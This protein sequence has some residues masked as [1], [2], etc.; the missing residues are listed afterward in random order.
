M[1]RFTTLAGLLSISTVLIAQPVITDVAPRAAAAGEKIVVR[2][3]FPSGVTHIQFTAHVGG[4][5]GVD[6]KNVAV[7]SA[8]PTMVKVTVPTMA[9]FVPPNAVPPGNPVGSVRARDASGTFSAKQ[10]FVFRQCR[11][12][13]FEGFGA[14]RVSGAK[15]VVLLKPDGGKKERQLVLPKGMV[16]PKAG[17]RVWVEGTVRDDA[18]HVARMLVLRHRRA[19]DIGAQARVGT[20]SATLTRVYAWCDHMPGS[21]RENKHL[22]VDVTL[23]NPGSRP[24]QVRFDPVFVSLRSEVEGDRTKLSVRGAD[25]MGTGKTAYSLAP[26]KHVVQL[27]G[28]GVFPEGRHGKPLWVTLVISRGKDRAT[29]R[30]S[31]SVQVTH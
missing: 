24:V 13:P 30:R 18:L 8:T 21:K 19:Q 1:F 14:V 3:K 27:R 28:D 6:I 31:G 15:K 22:I 7:T 29:I 12:G 26:G 5:L 2:G 25:G 10:E 9:A 20:I 4:F 11:H 23:E 17:T 16:V